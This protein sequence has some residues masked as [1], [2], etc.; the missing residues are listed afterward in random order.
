MCRASRLLFR[1]LEMVV[2]VWWWLHCC[3]FSFRTCTSSSSC[4]MLSHL[5]RSLKHLRTISNYVNAASPSLSTTNGPS[6]TGTQREQAHDTLNGNNDDNDGERDRTTR[7]AVYAISWATV[8][9][10][11]L[12]TFLATNSD[13]YDII[14][15]RTQRTRRPDER[16]RLTTMIGG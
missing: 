13:Y 6:S 3:C 5:I 1:V 11:F 4:S 14:P 7:K 15:L 16:C 8:C 10:F 2:C 12:L 9:S